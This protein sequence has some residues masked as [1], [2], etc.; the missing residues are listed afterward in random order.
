VAARLGFSQAIIE[1]D[2]WVCW[3]LEKFFALPSFGD[4]LV[5]KVGT[6]LSKA[7][8]AIQRFSEDV[9]LSLDRAQLGFVGD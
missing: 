5:F 9:D 3:L 6:S 2:F 7:Y 8:S 4:H 1:K